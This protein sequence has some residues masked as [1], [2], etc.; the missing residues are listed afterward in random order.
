MRFFP[1]LSMFSSYTIL[2]MDKS[3]EEKLRSR[4]EH[5]LSAISVKAVERMEVEVEVDNKRRSAEI[6]E[7]VIKGDVFRLYVRIVRVN[8][9]FFK[10]EELYETYEL[11]RLP[12]PK[13]TL[14]KVLSLIKEAGYDVKPSLFYGE[15]ENYP[16]E[17]TEIRRGEK[18]R[19]RYL[20]SLRTF[21]IDALRLNLSYKAYGEGEFSLSISLKTT[22]LVDVGALRYLNLGSY[23]Y[24]HEVSKDKKEAIIGYLTMLSSFAMHAGLEIFNI[25]DYMSIIEVMQER[26]KRKDFIYSI[27]KH[28]SSFALSHPNFGGESYSDYGLVLTPLDFAWYLDGFSDTESQREVFFSYYDSL[29]NEEEKSDEE[30]YLEVLGLKKGATRDEIQKAYKDIVQRFHPDRISSLGL[31]PSFT[32]FAN[33]QMQRANEAYDALK[34]MLTS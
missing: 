21:K 13:F 3:F 18:G 26:D 11:D 23:D 10:E 6:F 22:E 24:V 20:L 28:K 12:C 34:K 19:A 1:L 29:M 32:S 15:R 7:A 25:V 14:K 5:S 30:R 33:A 2:G 17:K 8:K 31:D 9:T 16:L 27:D 4:F